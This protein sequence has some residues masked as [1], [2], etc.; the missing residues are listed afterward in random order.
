MSFCG[1][2]KTYFNKCSLTLYITLSNR[3]EVWETSGESQLSLFYQ[4]CA[5]IEKIKQAHTCNY[6]TGQKEVHQKV[7]MHNSG[8]SEMV[9]S[10]TKSRSQQQQKNMP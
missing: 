7:K 2:L 10:I 3:L 6:H 9:R 5:Q 4:I 1:S 8:K